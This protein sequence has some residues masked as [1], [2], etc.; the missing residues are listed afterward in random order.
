VK[1]I[2]R[3]KIL[4]DFPFIKQS[5]E[6]KESL[7]KLA[8]LFIHWNKKHN[9]ISKD[10]ENILWERHIFDSLRVYP[11]LRNWCSNHPNNYS[12]LDMGSGMGFPLIPLAISFPEIEFHS[13][14]PRDKR[15]RILKQFKRELKL[16]N[17]Y[18][19]TGKAEDFITT[20][21]ME[22]FNSVSCRALGNLYED[23]K[24]AEP[25]LKQKGKFITFKSNSEKNIFE[26]PPW[27]STPY[28]NMEQI[29]PYYIVI[30]EK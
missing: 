18:F 30:R 28:K 5:I 22:F 7:Q 14:E 16:D 1:H 2:D 6:I 24:R 26:R 12:H 27:E 8:E 11:S 23:W 25:F 17:I 15:V 13:I 20:D 29:E 4:D 9:L 19:N 21:Y 3:F 10:D